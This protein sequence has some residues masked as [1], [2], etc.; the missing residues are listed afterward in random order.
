MSAAVAIAA[1]ECAA[2]AL[3]VAAV[4]CLHSPITVR[5][6]LGIVVP[7]LHLRRSI[8][9]HVCL[10]LLFGR[11]RRAVGVPLLFVGAV[12]VLLLCMGAVGVLLLLFGRRRGAVGLLQVRGSPCGGGCR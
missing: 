3:V 6:L 10:L 11:R 2:V 8:A 12:S 1:G 9:V 7:L 4:L 5:L